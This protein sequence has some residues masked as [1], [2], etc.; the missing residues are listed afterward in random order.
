MPATGQRRCVGGD[1]WSLEMQFALVDGQRR[2]AKPGLSGKCL[3]CGATMVAKCGAVRVWHWAHLGKRRCDVWWEPETTWHRDWKNQFPREWREVIQRA[4]DGE[5]HVADVKT[6]HGVAVEFQHSHLR[7][8]ERRAR[9]AFY[10]RMAWVVDGLRRK[11]DRSR[12][13]EAL[14]NRG[15]VVRGKP[16]TLSIP[17]DKGALLRDWIDS[18]VPVFFDFQGINDLEDV[19]PFAELWRLDP[20]SPDGWAHLAPVRRA[21][22][23]E[24]LLKGAGIKGIDFSKQLEY[25]PK[26]QAIRGRRATGF[27]QYMARKRRARFR[28]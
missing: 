13:F 19:F 16:L 14:K 5:K 21:D 15:R 25:V 22:F 24:A 6:E 20:K 28:F 27:Q 9:E 2:E 17:S 7:P 10:R 8:E 4:K 1:S 12:F 18:R 23:I 11:T 26:A 3:V